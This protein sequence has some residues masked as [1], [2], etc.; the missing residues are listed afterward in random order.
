MAAF[1][2]NGGG[3][4]PDY[5]RSPLE[6]HLVAVMRLEVADRGLSLAPQVSRCLRRHDIHELISTCEAGAPGGRIGQTA[7]LGFVEL[8]R[9]GVLMAGDRLLWG[10]A[11]LGEVLGFDE[12]HMPNHINI[13]V[14]T[15]QPLTGAQRGLRLGDRVGFEPVYSER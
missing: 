1:D 14:R 6:G 11:V 13:V 3:T 5:P 2:P 8:S 9:G 12:T 10:E 15:A 7:Y 4:R